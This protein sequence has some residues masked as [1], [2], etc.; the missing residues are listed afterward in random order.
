MAQAGRWAA[1]IARTPADARDYMIE[2][3]GGVLRNTAPASRP[4][5]EPSKRRLTW[6]NGS[7]ATIYS[8]DE[9]DQLRGFSGD[10][11]W[12]DEAAKFK[13]LREC[14][15]NLQFGMRE[16]SNDRPRRLISTT[17]RPIPLLRAL[18]KLPT[19]RVVTGASH[20]NRGNLDPSWFTE[21]ILSY[22]G[23]RLGRQEIHA[24][25]VEDILGALWSLEMLDA[26]QVPPDY[27]SRD[28]SPLMQRVVVS[29]D[30]SG[31]RGEDDK[32]SDEIGISVC[33]LGSDGVAYV[34][35]DYSCRLP[36]E[37]WAERVLYAWAKHKAD[38]V[39]AEKNFGGDMVRA[40]IES[41]ANARGMLGVK[42]E[43][44]NADAARGK[45]IR[46]EPVAALYGS[47]G[48]NGDAKPGKIRHVGRF[49]ELEDQLISF[50]SAGYMG[51]K[52]PDRADAMIWAMWDLIVE[53]QDFSGMWARFGAA[54]N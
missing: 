10:T 37:K 45:I 32:R 16:S 11:A 25:Y 41:Q 15:D 46:A 42:V 18:E 23:T 50:S 31:C 22:E 51:E 4:D 27:L 5:Y 30:P 8:D 19:T 44:V 47:I 9:P 53:D 6:P 38:K 34:L 49:P 35:A 7:W 39:V 40:V 20:E 24:E 33:G 36:P 1:L 48:E 28:D 54:L 26:C 17:P 2:G 12:L 43:L 21:T 29:V 52:S 14:W 13:N 3:P